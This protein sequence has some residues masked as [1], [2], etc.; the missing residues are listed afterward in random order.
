MI[1]P[2]P[3]SP[4][5]ALAQRCAIVAALTLTGVLLAAAI[6]FAPLI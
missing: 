3:P 4:I 1:A 5:H 6:L 2:P